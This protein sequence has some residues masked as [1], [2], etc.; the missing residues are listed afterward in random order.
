[1]LIWF[2]L[3]MATWIVITNFLYISTRL[4]WT[5]I[6]CYMSK[7]R[8][9]AILEFNTIPTLKPIAFKVLVKKYNYYIYG[10][11]T[12]KSIFIRNWKLH[13]HRQILSLWSY[14]D[15]QHEYMYHSCTKKIKPF[16]ANCPLIENTQSFRETKYHKMGKQFNT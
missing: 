8:R 14:R 10:I 2:K 1:M 13:D 15:I 12:Q 3:T 9:A 5:P 16:L 7:A 6:N 4:T 11:K